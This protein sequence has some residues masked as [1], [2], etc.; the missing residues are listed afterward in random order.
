MQLLAASLVACMRKVVAVRRQCGLWLT[1]PCAVAFR[2]LSLQRVPSFT[3]CSFGDILHTSTV[4]KKT[5]KQTNKQKQLPS[6]LSEAICQVESGEII[7]KAL[8]CWCVAVW[9]P[10][11]RHC[12]IKMATE[13]SVKTKTHKADQRQS[14]QN[15]LRLGSCTEQW[16]EVGV[17]VSTLARVK[18]TTLYGLFASERPTKEV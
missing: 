11:T 8:S 2:P 6:E 3:P 10:W 13:I 15:R 1:F 17:K 14:G 9:H 4:K 12:F 18:R 5:T 7:Q 16:K